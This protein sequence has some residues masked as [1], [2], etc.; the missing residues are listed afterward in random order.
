MKLQTLRQEF[1]TMNMKHSEAVQEFISRMIA[2]INQMR[3][4]G[5][6]IIDQTVIAKVLRSLTPCF[7]H[8][9]TAIEESK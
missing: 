8:V 5:D 2:I 3:A 6:N 7:D 1:E 9:D 4:F